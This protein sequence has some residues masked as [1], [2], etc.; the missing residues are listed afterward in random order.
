MSVSYRA[1]EIGR[2]SQV[3][4]IIREVDGRSMYLCRYNKLPSWGDPYEAT[5]DPAYSV[6]GFL[7]EEADIIAWAL[8]K[9]VN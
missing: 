9:S 7:K 6:L 2:G 3:Y 1:E 5:S 4:R 8:N